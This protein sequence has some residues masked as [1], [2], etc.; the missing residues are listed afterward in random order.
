MEATMKRI[1]LALIII[2]TMGQLGCNAIAGTTKEGRIDA[3][4]AAINS[5]NY[6]DY[7]DCFES[8]CAFKVPG[9]YTST[10]F[11]TDYSGKNY[12]FTNINTSSSDITADT[13]VTGS[14]S[15]FFL[16]HFTML[17]VDD[18]YYIVSWT[19]GTTTIFNNRQP[20]PAQ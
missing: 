13:T 17:K 20:A 8:N 12:S 2:T 3:L 5:H 15:A 16:S 10:D 4:S 19:D 11:T 6:S 1:L 14:S 9:V 18:I 7:M